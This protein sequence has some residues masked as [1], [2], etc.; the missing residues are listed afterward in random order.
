MKMIIYAGK[1]FST[2]FTVVSSD[3][4]TGEV[5]DPS[6]DTGTMT[7]STNSKSPTCIMNNIPMTIVDAANGVFN[8]TIPASETAKLVQDV[9]FKED[10]FA[11]LSNYVGFL[12]FNLASGKRSAMID[13]FVKEVGCA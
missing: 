1:E 5:L 7:I 8:V 3:G 12:E 9:G 6:T 13:L 2:D 10:R 4:V 11:P